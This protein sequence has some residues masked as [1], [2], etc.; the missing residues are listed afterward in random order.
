M[1]VKS[2]LWVFWKLLAWWLLVFQDYSTPAPVMNAWDETAS[3]ELKDIRHFLPISR[4]PAYSIN[5]MDKYESLW[6]GKVN[7]EAAMD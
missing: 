4:R 2:I 7:M 6:E 5:V 1:S 3:V